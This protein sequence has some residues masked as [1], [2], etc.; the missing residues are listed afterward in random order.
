MDAQVLV[1][2]VSAWLLGST[3]LALVIGRMIAV[4]D[5]RDGR[6]P[7]VA[8]LPAAAADGAAVRVVA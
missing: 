7:D 4:A 2:A 6:G 3:G 1:I 8:P 5:L